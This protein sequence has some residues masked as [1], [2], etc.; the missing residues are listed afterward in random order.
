[1]C[2]A[3]MSQNE[4]AINE[5]IKNNSMRVFL[6]ATPY[7]SGNKSD[8]ESG[9]DDNFFY[10]HLYSHSSKAEEYLNKIWD[11]ITKDMRRNII[12]YGYQGCG[13]TTFVHY[14]LRRF[15]CRSLLI[16]F[17]AYVDNGNEI[18]HELAS[19]LYRVI[20][21][22]VEGSDGTDSRISPYK[23]NGQK[24]IISRKFCDLYNTGANRRIIIIFELVRIFFQRLFTRN[25]AR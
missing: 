19:H 13:K 21:W 9:M 1:M 20:M 15:S 2:M 23:L 16:N 14:M 25:R 22:D 3:R 8:L 10:N 24:C 17:D 11:R 6:K 18:K 12:L 5:M 4:E 7:A